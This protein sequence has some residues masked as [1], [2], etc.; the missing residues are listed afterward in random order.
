MKTHCVHVRET[1]YDEYIGRAGKG[2]DGYFGNPFPPEDRNC[3]KSVL[4]SIEQ[5]RQYFLAR[6]EVDP[7]FRER[8]MALKGKALGC[9]CK[10]RKTPNKPCHGDVIVEWLEGPALGPAQE[11][12]GNLF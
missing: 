4:A 5:F 10:C 11:I 1:K 12:Q 6:V 3:E 8:A 9:F 7:T 2:K